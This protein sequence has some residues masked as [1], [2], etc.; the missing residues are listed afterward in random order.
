M[1]SSVDISPKGDGG[2]LKEVIV[3]G[4][5]DQPPKGCKVQVHYTGTLLDG[6]Q[7]DSSR[8][9][10]TP[11]EFDLG[12]GSVIKAWDIGVAT[13]KKGERAILTCAPEYAYGEKGSP[14]S[15]PPDSTLK[16]DVEIIG[17]KGE[18]LSP[19]KDGGIERFIIEA[20]QG[21][22]TPNDGAYVGVHLEGTYNGNT[23]EN[24]EVFFC[25]GEGS[26]EKVIDGVEIALE[27]FKMGE[28]SK[29]VIKP[30][31]AFG[32]EGSK[33]YNIP[34]DATLEYIVTLNT[35]EKMKESWSMDADEKVEQAKLY[36][37]KGTKY[38]KSGKFGLATK[39]YKKVLSYVENKPE[40][41]D[42][43]KNLLLT[44]N[45]NLALCY[46]KLDDHFEAVNS[47]TA[48]INIDPK[49]EKAFFRRGLALLALGE[50]EK[51]TKDF[52]EVLNLE[53]NNTAA[54]TQQLIC[55]KKLK[56]QLQREKKIYANMFDKFA[57]TDTQKE[58]DEKKK[59]PDVM[60]SLGEWGKEDRHREPSEFEKENPN[61]LMLN[62][63]GEF[64]DM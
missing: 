11:F 16:F 33:E 30:Q 38:F 47:A 28:K 22:A 14:P 29:L 9:R 42:E 51:A 59:Q 63:S 39:M 31:Y 6:T 37:E 44:S 32:A 41:S 15:I 56:E 49:S 35:F 34:P 4:S 61:I 55:T 18:D 60:S 2:V 1:T 24:R 8:D 21:Y 58:E 7:F 25:L 54:K 62:G 52:A 10:K 45:L 53:P 57:K 26:E 17:W 46:I 13:M 40:C 48:A 19:K 36:K 43:G 20:G 27:K 23:F 50:P 12:K 5:G 3:D 64:K